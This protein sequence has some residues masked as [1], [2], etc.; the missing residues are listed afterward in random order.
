MTAGMFHSMAMGWSIRF[1]CCR[2]WLNRPLLES[3]T[4]HANDR[5]TTLVS[6]GLTRTIYRRVRTHLRLAFTI[7]FAAGYATTTVMTVV[8]A[9]TP[10]VTRMSHR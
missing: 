2:I 5:T 7:R 9:A 10:M 3:S 1:S 4:T 6:R 8:R